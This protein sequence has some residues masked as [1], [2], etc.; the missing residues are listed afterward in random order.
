MV[1]LT[2]A[3]F[4]AHS[5]LFGTFK[6]YDD[7][8]YVMISLKEFI[9]GV[10]L[11]DGVFSQ[12]GPFFF[13]FD[14]AFF[15]IA[16]LQIDHTT[17]RWLMMAHW[18]VAGLLGFALVWRTT[19][20]YA[21]AFASC[22]LIL[23]LLRR[24]FNEPGHPQSLCALLVAGAALA[25]TCVEG[26]RRRLALVALGF[27]AAAMLLTKIN[28]GVY[29][30]LGLSLAIAPAL[31]AGRAMRGLRVVLGFAAVLLPFLVLRAHL[32]LGWG[33]SY[34][35][36]ASCA[37]DAALLFTWP[38]A[39]R[40]ELSMRDLLA[41]VAALVA[42]ALAICLFVLARGT[43]MG[44]LVESVLLRALRFPKTFQLPAAIGTRHA[45]FA[46]I[47]LI[48]AI[49]VLFAMRKRV[50][51]GALGLALHAV[52]LVFAVFVVYCVILHQQTALIGFALPFAWI[53]LVPSPCDATPPPISFGRRAL[54]LIAV[55]Q[56]LVAY[57]VAGSQIVFASFLVV[58]VAAVAVSD[59]LSAHAS[60]RALTT[61]GSKTIVAVEMTV[62]LA[63]V[64]LFANMAREDRQSIASCV[65]LGLPGAEDLRLS[66]RDVATY[67]WIAHNLSALSDTFVSEPGTNSLY[68][69]TQRAPPTAL[70][71]FVWPILLDREE[72][73]RIVDSIAPHPRA[74]ALRWRGWRGR[75]SDLPL[76][77]YL[78]DEFEPVA[79][80]DAYTLF[81]RRGRDAVSLVD[82]AQL[83]PEAPHTIRLSV[84]AV[85]SRSASRVVV[86][87]LESNRVF[88]DSGAPTA[89]R[90]LRVRD[91]RGE[92]FEV[93]TGHEIA[94]SSARELTLK[95]A[96]DLD[97][98]KA[99][100][101][102]VRLIDA[103]NRIVATLPIVK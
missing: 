26:G 40:A 14:S 86:C 35:A 85:G 22:T 73:Q 57:P 66:E 11:Y 70:N 21:L 43:T 39:D 38:R 36:V 84:L 56:T 53:V 78:V 93:S 76:M 37:I 97:L 61:W 13:L 80:C 101:P 60:T 95:P 55:L 1:L 27:L 17:I 74:C 88:S 30:L 16:P 90:G 44:G 10:P 65:P 7:E 71:C 47:S 42:S 2:L 64:A 46:C 15:S 32:D 48:L 4:D 25:C 52:K 23:V 54:V 83:V 59:V 5:V 75:T 96:A 33:R 63:C 34:A 89:G 98:S 45:A 19:R 6:T 68:L 29:L 18:L 102:V 87:D 51:L 81:V 72:Q 100:F 92:V 50:S 49:G 103:E 94:L 8:G 82:C 79:T 91:E 20:R 31:P 9:A 24:S 62:V 41:L 58:A 3:A 69:W 67:R 28:L 99:G 77:K 12:Y